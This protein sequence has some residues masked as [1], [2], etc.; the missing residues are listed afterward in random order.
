MWNQ[1]FV[2]I[3]SLWSPPFKDCMGVL[4]LTRTL[5]DI[6]SI[7]GNEQTVANYLYEYLARLA[8]DTGGRVEQIEV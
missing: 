2:A 1:A 7:T 4:E 6:E 3:P 8:A 5:I